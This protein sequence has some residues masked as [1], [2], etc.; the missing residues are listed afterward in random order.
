LAGLTARE[1]ETL[2]RTWH[3]DWSPT[4]VAGTLANMEVLPDGTISP[5]LSLAHHLA[6]V[7]QLWE[8]HPPERWPLV[9]V[10]VLL[11]PSVLAGDE[12]IEAAEAALAPGRL[13]VARFPGADH[14]V[15]VQH[16]VEVAD[17]LHDFCVL[18]G[19]G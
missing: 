17:L 6:V 2:V 5:W 3:P 12:G 1:L 16:P 10:P 9:S 7:R 8:H 13:R 14:D 4:G 19:A 18:G 15:H 11:I